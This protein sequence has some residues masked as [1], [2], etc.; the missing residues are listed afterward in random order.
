M[1]NWVDR[2][3]VNPRQRILKNM[4][5]GETNIYEIQDDDDNIDVEGTP[6][7]GANLK[8]L[9]ESETKITIDISNQDLNNFKNNLLFAYGNNCINRPTLS[10]GSNNG[11]LQV[12]QH[13]TNPSYCTQIWYERPN[14]ETYR[15]ICENEI[16]GNWNRI[17][18]II[19][20]TGVETTTDEFIDE[21]QVY[22]K[23]INFGALP[24]TTTKSVA[25]G[26]TN[27]TLVKI[28]GVSIQTSSNM[29]HP[30]PYFDNPIEAG[31]RLQVSATNVNITTGTNRSDYNAYVDLYYTKN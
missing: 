20:K 16:W 18:T 22:R 11:Y 17:S 10:D 25:H 23:R 7:N 26:L 6:V 8:A 28:N 21:K 24:N 4:D 27:Y 31:V 29:T 9:I 30:L 13:A 15:R 19:I 3:F 14:N 1:I 5:T 12:I 2:V